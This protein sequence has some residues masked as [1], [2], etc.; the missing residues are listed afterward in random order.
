MDFATVSARLSTTRPSMSARATAR[1]D[2]PSASALIERELLASLEVVG[3]PPPGTPTSCDTPWSGVGPKHAL[4]RSTAWAIAAGAQGISFVDGD[5]MYGRKTRAV[6]ALAAD[7][8]GRQRFCGG[9]AFHAPPSDASIARIVSTSRLWDV[10]TENGGDASPP[11]ARDPGALSALCCEAAQSNGRELD[12]AQLERTITVLALA[13]EAPPPE[14]E[15]VPGQRTWVTFF[16][17]APW[18]LILRSMSR[19][20]LERN[21]DAGTYLCVAPEVLEPLAAE[22]AQRTHLGGGDAR[23]VASGLREHDDA[24]SLAAAAVRTRAKHARALVEH[25]ASAPCA[26]LVLRDASALP[27]WSAPAPS[28]FA[29]LVASAAWL[30]ALGHEGIGSSGPGCN[31]VSAI[32]SRWHRHAPPP[33]ARDAVNK[34]LRRAVA[35]VGDEELLHAVATVAFAV[36]LSGSL[37]RVANALALIDCAVGVPQ[38]TLPPAGLELPTAGVGGA[39]PPAA[40]PP[41]PRLLFRHLHPHAPPSAFA[42]FGARHI[43]VGGG[44]RHRAPPAQA[45]SKVH[46]ALALT[47]RRAAL[48]GAVCGGWLPLVEHLLLPASTARMMLVGGGVPVAI[49]ADGRPRNAQDDP[50]RSFLQGGEEVLAASLEASGPHAGAIRAALLGVSTAD[51]FAQALADVCADVSPRER[52]AAVGAARAPGRGAVEWAAQAVYE[53]SSAD[54]RGFVEAAYTWI[55]ALLAAARAD[56]VDAVQALCDAATRRM[57]GA[58]GGE[59]AF[60]RGV[61][62]RVP[63]ET[64][65]REAL[66]AG[67]LRVVKMLHTMGVAWEHSAHT[68]NAA[69]AAAA[70]P[71]NGAALSWLLSAGCPVHVPSALSAALTAGSVGGVHALLAHGGGVAAPLVAPPAAPPL[72]LTFAHAHAA[73]AYADDLDERGKVRAGRGEAVAIALLRELVA[74]GCPLDAR[75]VELAA[76]RCSVGLLEV[77]LPVAALANEG[78]IV[79]AV[80]SNGVA[81]L[82]LWRW[83]VDVARV[84]WTSP[85]ACEAFEGGLAADCAAFRI[86]GGG[87]AVFAPDAARGPIRGDDRWVHEEAVLAALGVAESVADHREWLRE[88]DPACPCRGRHHPRGF[89]RPVFVG[90]SA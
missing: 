11:E 85:A 77:L 90:G 42:S 21:W 2:A 26:R 83:A 5:F 23:G 64:A 55:P 67:A 37:P 72:L 32:A 88:R 36:G 8:A 1:L 45:T 19:E 75:A 20:E 68:H 16:A 13:S 86:D 74:H 43:G 58:P 49:V 61:E 87:G 24:C 39:R 89:V 63:L 44:A 38:G 41:A 53:R 14:C 3:A 9:I 62:R 82:P 71:D 12:A 70:F 6:N 17:E 69:T 84:P 33:C 7:A 66:A 29:D 73:I 15:P 81:A 52:E 34:E 46:L 40:A 78:L 65:K 47:A 35:T 51:A 4:N 80:A 57:N 48:L 50:L 31:A 30:L 79:R 10:L 76:E 25:L 28:A 59:F 22:L 56:D 18:Y 27:T 60:P 54:R